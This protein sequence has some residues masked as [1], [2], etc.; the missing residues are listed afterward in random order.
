MPGMI[1]PDG[2]PVS[3]SQSSLS[4]PLQSFS[5]LSLSPLPG[6][7][8][9]PQDSS[10]S[11]Q[12]PWLQELKSE[13]RGLWVIQLLLRCATAV[14]CGQMDYTNQCLEQLSYLA[15][16]TGDPM[17]R[18]A[19]YF[20]EGLAA[21][22]TKSWSG[23]YKALSCTHLPSVSDLLSARQIFFNLCPYLKFA[24]T[25]VNKCVLDVMEGE[26]VVHIIDLGA[27]EAIQWVALLQVLSTRAGGPPHLRITIVN[28]RKEV[29]DHVGQV[30]SKEA[31]TLDIPFQF[32][33]VVTK[34]EHLD[35][36]MLKVKTGEAVAVSS[37]LQLHCL[38]SDDERPRRQVRGSNGACPAGG[39]QGRLHCHHGSPQPEEVGLLG[40]ERS[41]FCGLSRRFAHQNGGG[42]GVHLQHHFDERALKRNR[43]EIMVTAA[44]ESDIYRSAYGMTADLTGQSSSNG[45]DPTLRELIEK[46][47]NEHRQ[48]LNGRAI[49]SMLEAPI[50]GGVASP[51]GR[52]ECPGDFCTAGI[53]GAAERTLWMLRSLAP[54]V[55]VVMEHESNHNSPNLE[56]RFVEALHYYSAMF[57]ALESTLPQKLSAE[58]L[59]LEKHM[60][61]REIHNIVACE[62]TERVERHEKL[63]KWKK[64]AEWAGFSH[65][66]FHY[67]TIV[68]AK[69]LL[70]SYSSEGYRLLEDAGC[71]TVC[72]QETPLFSVSAWR[73]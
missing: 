8:I 44:R 6:S 73:I 2:S 26:K 66:P 38:L 33:P 58:R 43:E 22:I 27:S 59:K 51:S 23:L 35:V 11:S 45:P 60:F 53:G 10:V 17:Q 19:S 24:F 48:I 49:Q 67:S 37:V 42:E 52:E 50:H 54:K 30:L 62:G 25:I 71:L 40:R 55:M 7:A 4:S 12:H 15:S 21:R 36:E 47:G 20:M 34:L 28:E 29:L 70:I 14:A 63:D 13:D 72:W 18:V 9:S 64:R 46:E 31:E 56:E 57:D 32:H 39:V 61:G 41:L 5:S 69:R 3:L 16:L 1:Q 65:V 68:Q